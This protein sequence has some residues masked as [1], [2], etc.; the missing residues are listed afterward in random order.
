[1]YG[2]LCTITFMKL[3]CPFLTSA[4]A[5]QS[6]RAVFNLF[7]VN[8]S[9]L[10]SVWNEPGDK[11]AFFSECQPL[12]NPCEGFFTKVGR[13]KPGVVLTGGFNRPGQYS[14]SGQ[15]WSIGGRLKN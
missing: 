4:Y 5:L 15:Y 7:N 11:T 14:R 10:Q 6:N 8:H 9:Y 12:Q 13:S 1:M 3:K 2:H